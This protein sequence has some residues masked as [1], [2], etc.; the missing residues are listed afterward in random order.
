VGG[1]APT[2]RSAKDGVLNNVWFTK[3]AAVEETSIPT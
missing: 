3:L 2:E 1:E